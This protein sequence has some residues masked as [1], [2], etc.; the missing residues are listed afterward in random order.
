MQ[1]HLIG[2]AS[3]QRPLPRHPQATVEEHVAS[4]REPPNRMENWWNLSVLFAYAFNLWSFQTNN[5][6]R[7]R[8]LCSCCM[9][10]VTNLT[11]SI[12]WLFAQEVKTISLCLDLAKWNDWW[13]ICFEE[14]QNDHSRSAAWLCWKSDSAEV[15]P[16]GILCVWT[17]SGG[18]TED[19]RRCLAVMLSI[20]AAWRAESLGDSVKVSNWAERSKFF[21][22]QRRV[23]QGIRIDRYFITNT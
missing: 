1:V 6:S 19:A 20:E 10:Y 23:Q 17:V 18:I 8:Q 12:W 16:V 5:I 14:E 15:A 21:Q 4:S 13:L 2:S 11:K 7:P 9:Q 22:Q 3:P